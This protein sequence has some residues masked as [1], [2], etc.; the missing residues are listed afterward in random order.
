VPVG[1]APGVGL[2][3]REPVLEGGRIGEQLAQKRVMMIEGQ[4]IVQSLGLHLLEEPL[5]SL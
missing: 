1:E 5:V 3:S 2:K 4:R